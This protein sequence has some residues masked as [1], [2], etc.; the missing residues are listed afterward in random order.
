MLYGTTST[1]GKTKAGKITNG[2]IYRVNPSTG[3]ISSLAAF[4]P[5]SGDGSNPRAGLTVVGSYLYGENAFGGAGGSTDGT[6]FRFDPVTGEFST[7]FRFHGELPSHRL[8]QRGA[9]LYGTTSQGGWAG[10]GTVFR[11]NPSNGAMTALASILGGGHS[12]SAL[13]ACGSLLYGTTEGTVYKFDP[14]TGVLTT[15]A[16]LGA[17]GDLYP[18]AISDL[19]CD[20]SFVFGTTLRGGAYGHGSVF[21]IDT[22]TGQLT[23]L[24]SFD[25]SNGAAP[26]GGLLVHDGYVYGTTQSGGGRGGG[27]LF[28]IAIPRPRKRPVR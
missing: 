13:T 26:F 2:T 9:Y 14:E 17:T 21:R 7:L 11:F 27:T 22:A 4:D 8:L 19:A 16:T 6:L 15:I 20:G 12:S 23:T 1:K 5:F 24:L 18:L 3:E 28:R 25:L 10:L